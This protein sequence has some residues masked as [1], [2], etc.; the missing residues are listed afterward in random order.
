MKRKFFISNRLKEVGLDLAD[1]ENKLKTF[2]ENNRSII[3]SPA[4]A[5]KQERLFREVQVQT[6]VFITL[7]NQYEIAQI[8]EVNDPKII[9][10]LNYPE[11]P[12]KRELVPVHQPLVYF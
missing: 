12:M 10:V 2:R 11:K 3:S 5:L 1:A 9:E 8:D 7:K 4:L 6:E